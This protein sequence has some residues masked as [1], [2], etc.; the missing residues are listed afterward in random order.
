MP[1][2][3]QNNSNNQT[4]GVV[5]T[6]PSFND[7]PPIP[8]DF[9]NVPT[10][11]LSASNDDNKTP[12]IPPVVLPS[13]TGP[14]SPTPNDSSTPPSGSGSAAPSDL[15][16]VITPPKKKFGGG[17][18]IATIL[19]LFLL[20][21][22]IGAGI[23]LTS[24]KQLF[25]QKADGG[26][27]GRSTL[28]STNYG[29][30]NTCS[31]GRC[32]AWDPTKPKPP[33]SVC[34][35]GSSCNTCNLGK[36]VAWDP[37]KPKPPDSVCTESSNPCGVACSA[38]QCHC[39]GGDACTGY[40]CYTNTQIENYCT[41]AGRSWC[42]NYQS[43]GGK[44][45]CVAGYICNPSGEGCVPGG[46]GSNPPGSGTPR[47]TGTPNPTASCQN[48]KAYSST[49]VLLSANDLSR[50]ARGAAINFCVTGTTTAGS[51]DKARF[52]INGVGP[53]ETTTRRPG[54]NDYCTAYTIPATGTT[55]NIT[56]DIHHVSLGWK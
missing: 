54:N 30:C 56:A 9:Q 8:P 46:G 47:P 7:A 18:V 21:G 14:T 17:R 11:P 1:D 19:G 16:P 29:T 42:D 28:P 20:V 45:C 3:N 23:V 36:C 43:G 41:G 49:W 48:V 12:L 51:F 38:N 52:T 33:D 10:D 32:V 25:E 13:A 22:G 37:T 26:I 6:I 5:P 35:G 31:N 40:E 55:F 34:T 50:L 53:T 27:G 15:P 2:P 44:T 39:T 24:Q 4:Q